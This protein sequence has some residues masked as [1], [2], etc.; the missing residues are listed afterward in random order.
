VLWQLNICKKR[1][2]DVRKKMKINNQVIDEIGEKKYIRE[3]CK[4]K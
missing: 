1:E 2:K 3:R 4:K